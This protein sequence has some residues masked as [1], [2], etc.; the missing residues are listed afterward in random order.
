MVAQVSAIHKIPM[1]YFG[2]GCIFKYD[3][4]HTPENGVGYTEEDIPNF[5]GSAYSLAKGKVDTI[6]RYFPNVLNARIRFPITENH[7]HK[8]FIT[9]IMNYPKILNVRN[10]MA[11][12]SDIVPTLI[13]LL[14]MSVG[15]TI[16]ATNPGSAEHVEILKLFNHTSYELVPKE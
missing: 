3:D 15:G 2:S 14:V 11:V 9:K 5:F 13:G 7:H 6:M 12:L 1:L 16:N 4:K 8:D 10:S